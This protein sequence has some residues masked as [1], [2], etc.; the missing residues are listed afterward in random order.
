VAGTRD[1]L[2]FFKMSRL[3]LGSISLLFIGYWGT[4]SLVSKAAT[5][6][7]HLVPSL[8]MSGTIPLLPIHVFMACRGTKLP[9]HACCTMQV[10][11]NDCWKNKCAANFNFA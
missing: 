3:A 11:L 5:T 2:L 10:F 1:F 8:R 7:L 9:V 6:Q 4:A